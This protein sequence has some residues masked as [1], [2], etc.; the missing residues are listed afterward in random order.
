M[1]DGDTHLTPDMFAP[2]GPSSDQDAG[3]V[4]AD[5]YTSVL[6]GMLSM[7]QRSALAGLLYNSL[8][9]SFGAALKEAL[10]VDLAAA[11]QDQIIS[12]VLRQKDPI[13]VKM[14]DFDASAVPGL[15]DS[16]QARAL[17]DE[18]DDDQAAQCLMVIEGVAGYEVV[19]GHA[20]LLEAQSEGRD[21]VSAIDVSA[22]ASMDWAEYLAGRITPDMPVRSA[23]PSLQ[24][25]AA[26]GWSGRTVV[27]SEDGT[28]KTVFHGSRSKDDIDEFFGITYFAEKESFARGFG[29][30]RVYAVELD[31]TNPYIVDGATEGRHFDW[32]Y[33][34]IRQMMDDGHDGIIVSHRD[35]D[36]YVPFDSGQIRHALSPAIKPSID[37]S[38]GVT[39]AVDY[40][41]DKGARQLAHAAKQGDEQSIKAMAARMAPS[42][43]AGSTLVPV[44]S[45]SGVATTSLQL[46]NAIAAITGSPVS[47]VLRGS[48]RPS[49]YDAKHAGKTLTTA[50]FGYSLQA[51]PG[52]NP[53][54]IDNVFATGTTLAAIRSALPGVPMVA[55][56]RDSSASVTPLLSV[57]SRQAVNESLLTEPGI[58]TIQAEASPLYQKRSIDNVRFVDEETTAAALA[59]DAV[60]RKII[61]KGLEVNDGDLVGVRLNINVLKST[62]VA[63]QT[64]H[65]GTPGIRKKM[66]SNPQGGSGFYDGSVLAYQNAVTLRNAYFN[67]NQKRREEIASGASSKTPMGSVDGAFVKTSTHNF[68]G[69]ELRFN[70]HREHLFIDKYGRSVRYADEITVMG[71]SGYA[72]GTI[73]Y[74]DAANYPG[75]SGPSKTVAVPYKEN[76]DGLDPV[77]RRGYRGFEGMS[78]AAVQAVADS[79]TT[80]WKNAPPITIVGAVEDLPFPAPHDAEGAYFNGVVYLVAGNLPDRDHCEFVLLHESLGHHGLR[81]V[82]GNAIE[83]H[84]TDLYRADPILQSRVDAFMAANAGF[85]IPGATEEVLAD[86]VAGGVE[87]LRGIPRFVAAVK[88]LVRE[89]GFGITLSGRDTL[90][91]VEKAGAYTAAG[92][93]AGKATTVVR[94]EAARFM[95]GWHNVSSALSGKADLILG[96][97]HSALA[98]AA[99]SL[100]QERGTPE[101][102]LSMLAKTPGVKMTEIEA[103]GLKD[104]LQLQG[105]SVTK[106]QI[107]EYLANNGI[108]L[109]ET[110]YG[111]DIETIVGMAAKHGF[112]VDEHPMDGEPQFF[113]EDL[114]EVDFEDLPEEVRAAFESL[115]PPKYAEQQSPGI[116]SGYREIVLS[117][118][119]STSANQGTT[120][121][122]PDEDATE[123]FLVDVSAKGYEHLDYGRLSDSPLTVEF[124]DPIPSALMPLITENKG[125][126]IKGQ[127]IAGTTF[128]G[129]HFTVPNAVGH[130]RLNLRDSG[131]GRKT[132]FVEEFQSDWAQEGRRKGFNGGPTPSDVA[133]IEVENGFS[134]LVD[135]VPVWSGIDKDKA[136]Q[137]AD[138]Q[139]AK[140]KTA[141][142]VPSAPFVTN[143]D[144]W[145]SLLMRRVI[146]FAVE[147]DADAVAWT[148]GD[149]QV[150]RYNLSKHLREVIVMQ[151]PE[152]DWNL[153]AFS[154]EGEEDR[155]LDVDMDSLDSL[156]RYIGK[157]LADKIRAEI[158]EKGTVTVRG[159]DLEMGGEG[160][161][162]F[163]DGIIPKVAKSIIGKMGS[164]LTR[165][166]FGREEATDGRNEL[167]GFQPGFAITDEMRATVRTVGQPL[168]SRASYRVSGQT[169]VFDIKKASTDRWLKDPETLAK[170]AFLVDMRVT[171]DLQNLVGPI[172]TDAKESLLESW[173][174]SDAIRMNEYETRDLT[175]SEMNDLYL[176]DIQS[177]LVATGDSVNAADLVRVLSMM[178]TSLDTFLEWA[179]EQPSLRAVAEPVFRAHAP[180]V[181][182]EIVAARAK[183]AQVIDF[184]AARAARQ[185]RA[186]GPDVL[187]IDVDGVQ[188]PT[189][190]SLNQPIFTTEEG[191]RNFWR[192]FGQSPATT[193]PEG[194]PLVFF[195]GTQ[196]AVDEFDALKINSR[197][198]LS[199]G[200]HFT[201]SP[202]EASIY[203]DSIENGAV[204]FKPTSPFAREVAE[205]AN[206]M[207]VYLRANTP[208]LYDSTE[209]TASLEADRNRDGIIADLAA[210]NAMGRTHDAVIINA[211]SG[212]YANTNVV[213][214]DAAQ[215]KS[216][217]GNTGNFSN[218]HTNVLYQPAYHGTP[219]RFSSF[220]LAHI[221]TG[222]SNAM[223]GW[224]LYFASSREVAEHYRAAL[225]LRNADAL[226]R[227]AIDSGL[228]PEM[229]DAMAQFYSSAK[230]TGY[231][232]FAAI[233]LSDSPSEYINL[234]R[235][236][237]IRP[238][239]LDG[240]AKAVWDSFVDAGHVYTVD[241][242]E[243][244]YLLWDKPYSEQPPLVQ[245]A[246]KQFELMTYSP[247]SPETSGAEIYELL[248]EHEDI[249][250]D[251]HASKFLSKHGVPGIQ[252][253]DGE[254]RN[255][256]G[257][258][259]NFVVFDEDAITILETHHQTGSYFDA[260][261]RA[262][263]ARVEIR[264]GKT[265]TEYMISLF[266]TANASTFVHEAGHVWLDIYEKL[267]A[268]PDA[269]AVIKNDVAELKRWMGIPEDQPI[270]RQ[271]HEKFAKAMEVY[272]STGQP[273]S[274]ALT[275]VF[276]GFRAWLGDLYSKLSFREPVTIS[277][278]IHGVMDR[279]MGAD[280]ASGIVATTHSE[281]L[282]AKLAE[283][284]NRHTA[285]HS[286]E[287]LANS[288]VATGKL[289]T[290]FFDV[291]KARGLAE[292]ALVDQFVI[293]VTAP[294]KPLS[295]QDGPEFKTITERDDKFIAVDGVVRPTEMSNGQ[296]IHSTIDGIRNFW[297]W[298]GDSKA[299]D[300]AGRPLAMWHGTEDRTITEFQTGRETCRFLMMAKFDAESQGHFFSASAEDA[301][302]YGQHLIPATLRITN[303]LQALNDMGLAE[304]E[305]AAAQRIVSD[306]RYILAPVIEIQSGARVI[307]LMGEQFF[308]VTD[309]M[310]ESGEW[311]HELADHQLHW[312]IFDNPEVISRMKE[313]GY[314]GAIAY[315][316]NDSTKHSYFV[317][318]STQIKSA[319]SNLGSFNQDTGNIYYQARSAAPTQPR[320]FD[321]M[322]PSIPP[323]HDLKKKLQ[324]FDANLTHPIATR[325]PALS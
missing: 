9:P 13:V 56:A 132:V 225:S 157:D 22:I 323:S 144:A 71:N 102:M 257:D 125:T 239:I 286:S 86:M 136:N 271:G 212:E 27:A 296:L 63:V 244:G 52:A 134:V 140:G 237:Y 148:T 73:Q 259:Y 59:K 101:Q 236:K 110:Q 41:G 87:K 155:A 266:E 174:G 230:V 142:G 192:W 70:P 195:H 33:T 77:F 202:V 253:L 200:F 4:V 43:P 143:T 241:I 121:V 287:G 310:L 270:H 243:D 229:A 205:G 299:I 149:Q 109:L 35:G 187:S 36:I 217:L 186:L 214:F 318:E 262:N 302:E 67:V 1:L 103:T 193:D 135:R 82:L 178:S 250:S 196:S 249:G 29:S 223:F 180:D 267:A 20:A 220:S 48:D 207:P 81:G 274:P 169:N 221:G 322:T 38:L 64:L 165:I 163:Y 51:D 94:A 162:A 24:K 317:L 85:T 248:A 261:A 209:I 246:L 226:Q 197:F 247:I 211:G 275:G 260:G 88:L 60:A 172:D 316:P 234:F 219:H 8:S 113:N 208:L 91:L 83:P 176:G 252:Y 161:R 23:T 191:V 66:E 69:I 175:F 222:E 269:P 12:C 312:S 166:Q 303:P 44:P 283:A 25:T 233:A 224:G 74:F 10:G 277:P 315:E 98:N 137:E 127:D 95:A 164:Q 80:Q 116:S 78:V 28:P 268:S 251:E 194:R 203:A 124:D 293:R 288:H 138:R 184:S 26:P 18:S 32:D 105:K 306:Y 320:D 298:F 206:V 153:R 245:A 17:E 2:P 19:Y 319:T 198:P 106:A 213:V 114:D 263:N 321:T 58:P 307:D 47:D 189:R 159:L 14:L 290:H 5:S 117:L 99:M 258:S 308:D 156:D 235:E 150:D 255:S 289:F 145:V 146:A 79:I 292:S 90:Y 65:A 314:D 170:L 15:L 75:P 325:G 168:F 133:V 31:I 297:Q 3:S 107:G 11:S 152:G 177:H 282:G 242:P 151:L 147:V 131:D 158:P 108:R 276:A 128:A 254:S 190:N 278:A 295:L 173:Y 93:R 215:V 111:G 46:A 199:F 313:C 123:T 100:K 304:M 183:T 309:D 126:I 104:Y 160:M 264:T 216:A 40:Y 21:R 285:H 141:P 154:V 96:T 238:S 118:P 68:D 181:F 76:T 301:A 62:G 171:R 201:S 92:A 112:T 53:V 72:R 120:I 324:E 218:D 185:P 57:A 49:L 227:H 97:F 300:Q 256:G 272:V 265:R 204:N 232:G 54:L 139:R 167:A 115:Q 210:A 42:I 305:P 55:F 294:T 273:P 231:D 7:A 182:D 291:L 240:S 311:V 84:L 129:R 50:D 179:I 130:V 30:E 228:P 6:A 284:A 34:D 281:Q 280:I 45:R 16:C 279:M 39:A 37:A 61:A 188:R 122:F 89:M 119:V